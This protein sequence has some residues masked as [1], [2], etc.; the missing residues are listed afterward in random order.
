VSA[1]IA[2]YDKD[3]QDSDAAITVDPYGR[4]LYLKAT[5]PGGGPQLLVLFPLPELRV[6]QQWN[7]TAYMPTFV[8]YSNSSSFAASA[9]GL[10]ALR[11]YGQGR[12]LQRLAGDSWSNLTLGASSASFLWSENVAVDPEDQ[13]HLLYIE[14]AAD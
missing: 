13:P 8:Y 6:V 1:F 4:W 3:R 7:A 5:V 9:P 11:D 10:I 2:P 12:L 14:T